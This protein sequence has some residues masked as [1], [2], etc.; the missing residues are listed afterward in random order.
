M[1][2]KIDWNHACETV[3]G[4]SDLLCELIEI[5]FDEHPKLTTGIRESLD[6][7]QLV[8]L[9]RFA[10]TMKGCLRYFGDTR[11]GELSL[12]LEA[13][14]RDKEIE[15]AEDIFTELK[16]ELDSLLPELKAFVASQ[17]PN[18]TD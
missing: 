1:S 17:P 14:A 12:E 4:S 15:Q 9:R 10:H 18:T 13:M 6:S 16:S 5:F 3:G 8:D 2:G 7:G 11:A